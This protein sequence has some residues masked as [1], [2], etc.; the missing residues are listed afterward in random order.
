MMDSNALDRSSY[1]GALQTNVRSQLEWEYR[2]QRDPA[3]TRN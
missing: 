1:V 2:L 3:L